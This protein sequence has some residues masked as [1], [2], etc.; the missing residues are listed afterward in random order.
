MN[1][2]PFAEYTY[3][4]R[5]SKR[6]PLLQALHHV[7]LDEASVRALVPDLCAAFPLARPPALDLYPGRR[8]P[9]ARRWGGD[10][11]G[12]VY[13]PWVGA[14]GTV[15]LGLPSTGHV[16]VHEL[17]HHAVHLRPDGGYADRYN[18]PPWHG[19]DFVW[20]LDR[21][22]VSAAQALL[23]DDGVADGLR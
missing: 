17:A 10:S 7:L 20:R 5:H 11:S 4:S 2:L 13:L 9:A 6:L 14:V 15:R 22:A 18:P 23:D 12:G 3:V 1:P 8:G 16:V 19:W 21:L